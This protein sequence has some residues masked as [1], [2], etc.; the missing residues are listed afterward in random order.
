MPDPFEEWAKENVAPTDKLGNPIPDTSMGMLEAQR[1]A[2][3]LR[4]AQADLKTAELKEHLRTGL[5]LKEKSG[6]EVGDVVLLKSGGPLM[7]VSMSLDNED[8][9]VTWFSADAEIRRHTFS[10]QE[11]KPK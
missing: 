6:F 11:L 7:T 5:V 2:Q 3:E 9:E 8:Y 10:G 4:Q 1:V